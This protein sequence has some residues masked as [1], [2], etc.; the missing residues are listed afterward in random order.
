M[1]IF[2]VGF[3]FDRKPVPLYVGNDMAAAIFAER[4]GLESARFS[5]VDTYRNPIPEIV[6]DFTDSNL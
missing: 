5:R 3:T 6:V 1:L 4:V 2:T